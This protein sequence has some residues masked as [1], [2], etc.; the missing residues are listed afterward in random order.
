MLRIL[1]LI[2]ATTVPAGADAQN[3]TEPPLAPELT[4]GLGWLNVDK[5]VSLRELRGNVVILDFWTAGCVNCMH[6]LAVLDAL[7]TRREGQ[8][9]QIIGVHSAKFDS[10]KDPTRVLAAVERYGIRHPVVVDRDLA[11]WERYGVQA[12]PTL[13][14]VRPDGRVAGAI[15]GEIGLDQLDGI[16]GRVLDEAR[17]DGTLAP[18]PLLHHQSPHRAGGALSFPGKVLSAD[19]GRLFISD[20][21]HHRVLVAS[22][23]GRVLD[24]IGSGESGVA[25]GPF[26]SARFVEPQGLAFDPAHQRLFVADARGQRIVVADLRRKTVAALA[27]TGVLGT[28]PVGADSRPAR[29]VALRTPWDLALRG[30]TLYVALAGSHQLGVLDLR[31]GLAA[32]TLRRFAGTGRE[33]LRDGLPDESAFAQPSGLSIQGDVMFV[34]DSESSAIRKVDLANGSTTTLLGTGLFDWGDGDGPLRPRLLQ[35]PIAV[36]AAP[37]GLWIADTYN[38]KIKW[39]ALAAD[40]AADALRTVVVTAAGE[41]L[42]NP[43][44]LALE[45]DGSLIIADTDRNRLLR[46][47]PGASEPLVVTVTEGGSA[48]IVTAADSTAVTPRKHSE[49]LTLA[50]QRLRPGHQDLALQLSAPEGFAFSEGAP[51]SVDLSAEGEGLRIVDTHRDGEASGGKAVPFTAGVE[52]KDKATLIVSVRATVCDSVNHAACYPRRLRFRVPVQ[53]EGGAKSATLVLAL[54]APAVGTTSTR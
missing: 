11:I 43:S 19:D 2:V 51:W 27:G 12:W 13:V 17:A 9:L 38:R 42:G 50:A 5:P 16:V 33:A 24:V 28:A 36:A 14:V 8:P 52:A 45:S 30:D 49:E 40:P 7:E 47:P 54:T 46:L 41:P 34:A 39:L 3:G 37:G 31:H 23:G 29:E 35:H 1:A 15:P 6:M 18:G 32:A 20:T 44:G 25:D 21:G 53:V 26:A 10:E 22:S 48:P 4:G